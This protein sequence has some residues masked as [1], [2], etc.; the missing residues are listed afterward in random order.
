M[1]DTVNHSAS[2]TNEQLQ[3]AKEPIIK[4]PIDEQGYGSGFHDLSEI[5]THILRNQKRWVRRNNITKNP[6]IGFSANVSNFNPSSVSHAV[7][8]QSHNN[9]RSKLRKSHPINETS[10]MFPGNMEIS[11]ST[12]RL[13]P[14][15]NLEKTGNLT[16]NVRKSKLRQGDG[17]EK[18]SQGKVALI[19]SKSSRQHSPPTARLSL[20]PPWHNTIATRKPDLKIKLRNLRKQLA[21]LKTKLNRYI[22]HPRR[23]KKTNRNVLFPQIVKPLAQGHKPI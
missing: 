3:D 6:T 19:L 23:R 11:N 2:K 8:N 17:L 18:G 20:S 21:R 1:I 4:S 16:E 13:S 22:H 7:S 15:R 5:I 12:N 10:N 14:R 9:K